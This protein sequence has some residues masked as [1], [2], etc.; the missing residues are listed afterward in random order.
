LEAPRIGSDATAA[1]VVVQ[2]A[3]E[4]GRLG[5]LDQVLDLLVVPDLSTVHRVLEALEFRLEMLEAT[6]ELNDPTAA[7]PGAGRVRPAGGLEAPQSHVW[8]FLSLCS[9]AALRGTDRNL[10]ADGRPTA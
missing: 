2:G 6:L 7:I 5:R 9:R 1:G 3:D 4:L 10:R 8:S